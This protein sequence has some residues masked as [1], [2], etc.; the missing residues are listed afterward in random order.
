MKVIEFINAPFVF[1][2]TGERIAIF[3]IKGTPRIGCELTDNNEVVASTV[4]PDG[5]VGGQC[6]IK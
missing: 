1:T 6:P 4:D 3:D 2:N 5:C